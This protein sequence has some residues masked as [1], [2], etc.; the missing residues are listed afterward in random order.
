V[1]LYILAD[2]YGLERLGNI[3]VT[4][5][6]RNLNTENAT[7]ILQQAAD[8]ECYVIKD[9]AMDFVVTNF[10]RVSKTDGIRAVSHEL[11]LEILS[12]R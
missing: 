12:N 11:L 10:E 9:I 5:V 3:C 1:D 6:K 2:L 7:S 4:V 8:E